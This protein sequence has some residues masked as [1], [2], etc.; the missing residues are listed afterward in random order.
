MGGR[1]D[2]DSITMIAHMLKVRPDTQAT[3]NGRV[4]KAKKN[5]ICW[6]INLVKIKPITERLEKNWTCFVSDPVVWVKLCGNA[7]NFL[8]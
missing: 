4:H 5:Q 2:Q 1:V 6:N 8:N 3:L 7:S